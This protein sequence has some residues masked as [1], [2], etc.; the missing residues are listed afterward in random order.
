MSV[1]N[2]FIPEA[3]TSFLSAL[4]ETTEN[5][6]ITGFDS[7]IPNQF[8]TPSFL[9]C[10]LCIGANV[11][12]GFLTLTFQA[13]TPFGGMSKSFKITNNISFTW[14]P[15]GLFKVEVKITN[16]RKV[17]N[18]FSFSIS[19]KICIKVPILGWKCKTFSHTFSVP[20]V[21]PQAQQSLLAASATDDDDDGDD[22]TN[23][24]GTML[25]LQAML[26]EKGGCSCDD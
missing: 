13:S 4:P 23:V 11:I 12:G 9:G 15:V 25:L 18:K 3:Q 2:S 5:Q 24:Y 6:I 21:L 16:F 14:N 26:E 19:V 22:T 17:G 1:P 7:F 20:T 10:K 8:C